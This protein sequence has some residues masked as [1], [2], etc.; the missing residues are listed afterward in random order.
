MPDTEA[1]VFNYPEKSIAGPVQ[2]TANV[3][4]FVTVVSDALFWRAKVS[5][6]SAAIFLC[7]QGF[8]SPGCEVLGLHSHLSSLDIS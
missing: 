2:D 5:A 1:I 8:G 6:K 4:V 7:F 3:P